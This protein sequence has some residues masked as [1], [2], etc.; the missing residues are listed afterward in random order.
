MRCFV[1]GDEVELEDIAIPI[2]HL[3]DRLIVHTAS[4]AFS[5]AAIRQG[6]SILVSFKGRQYQ[7]DGRDPKVRVGVPIGSGEIRAPMPGLIVDI[8]HADGDSVQKG[9]TIIVLEAMK[10]Q[11]PFTSPFAGTVRKIHVKKGDQIM[12]GSLLAVVEPDGSQI[13]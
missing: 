4:G 6:D 1:N 3:A 12:D 7:I 13:E 10:T 11:Q 9:D 5:A 2:S 8:R